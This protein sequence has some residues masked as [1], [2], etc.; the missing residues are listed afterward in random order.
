MTRIRGAFARIPVPVTAAML[1]VGGALAYA[2][3]AWIR[4]V[5]EA[6]RPEPAQWVSYLTVKWYWALIPAAALALWAHRPSADSR[7]G[8]V[9]GWLALV[10]G[11][12]QFAVLLVSSLLWGLLLGRGELPTG[13]MVIEQ[14]G[15]LIPIGTVLLGVAMLRGR[16]RPR[17]PGALVVV[18]AVAA[19]LP[20]GASV[21][22]AVL[23]ALHVTDG[24]RRRRALD[25]PVAATAP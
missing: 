8:R 23:A 7:L 17:W 3:E 16:E 14:L 15:Y 4:A 12:L 10:G 25:S 24:R 9:G 2:H 21:T 11:P 13:L 18:L 1:V 5:Y 20:F 6:G 19:W 22:G